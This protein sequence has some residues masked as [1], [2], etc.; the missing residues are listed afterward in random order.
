MKKI[1]LY[2]TVNT[3]NLRWCY[4]CRKI[5]ADDKKAEMK[6]FTCNKKADSLRSIFMLMRFLL[7]GSNLL[8]KEQITK[9]KMARNCLNDCIEQLNN[10]VS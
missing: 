10:I 9:Q 4:R 2:E 3:N 8:K 5:Y 6:C 1:D 7:S